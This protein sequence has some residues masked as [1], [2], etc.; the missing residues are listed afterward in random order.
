MD[1]EELWQRVTE[2]IGELRVLH[3]TLAEPRRQRT[4]DRLVENLR[5]L[6]GWIEKG[7]GVP[8]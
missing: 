6:A 7:G 5:A 4:K 3:P 1:V 2:D 8:R